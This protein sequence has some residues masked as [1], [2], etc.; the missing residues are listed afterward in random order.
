MGACFDGWAVRA[1]CLLGRYGTSFWRHSSPRAW[2]RDLSCGTLVALTGEDLYASGARSLANTRGPV[3]RPHVAS[4]VTLRQAVDKLFLRIFLRE[5]ERQ[6]GFGIIAATDLSRALSAGD[7][8]RVWY[9]VQGFLVAAGNLSKL[10]WSKSEERGVTLRRNLG[11]SEGSVLEPRTFRN[12][13][14]HFDER[15]ETWASSSRRH[16]FADSNIGPKGEPAGL[17]PEDYLRNLDPETWTVTFRGDEYQL[18]P[19]VEAMRQLFRKVS[20]LLAMPDSAS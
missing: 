16:N 18:R 20:D 13:F 14:E 15:L 6:C 9:A 7:Q 11:V 8:Q 17:D 5:V 10:L 2:R 3:V 12:H 4:L 19:I 1:S